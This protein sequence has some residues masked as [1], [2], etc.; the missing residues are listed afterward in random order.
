MTKE[1]E[2]DVVSIMTKMKYKGIIEQDH[3]RIWRL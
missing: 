2:K 1:K 3:K